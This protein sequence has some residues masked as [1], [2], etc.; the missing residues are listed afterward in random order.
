MQLKS[1]ERMVARPT[2]HLLLSRTSL[3]LEVSLGVMEVGS[4]TGTWL[5]VVMSQELDKL[6]SS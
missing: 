1:N 5:F 6:G 4:T 3:G 2:E